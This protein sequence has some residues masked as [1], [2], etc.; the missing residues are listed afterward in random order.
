ML[1]EGLARPLLLLHGLAAAVLVA[2]STHHLLWCRSYRRGR[3][4]RVAAERRFAA[5]VAVAFATT[6]TVG[7]LLYPTYKVRVRAQYFD[8]PGAVA[9]VAD[10]AA[11]QAERLGHPSA[12]PAARDLTWAGRLFDVKEHWI[13]LGA[14]AALLLFVLS[15]R[16]HPSVHPEVVPLYLAHS[17]FVCASAWLAALVG[18]LTTA[19]RAVGAP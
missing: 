2:S 6:F 12:P 13:A 4:V 16:A 11:A 15:R 7:A 5:L 10:L 3:F 8:A 19:L 17:A 1:L 9:A 14:G 18:L